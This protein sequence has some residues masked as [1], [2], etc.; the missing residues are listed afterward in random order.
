[1]NPGKYMLEQVIWAIAHRNVAQDD[2]S[3][4]GL[5]G[6]QAARPVNHGGQRLYRCVKV[7]VFPTG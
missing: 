4:I 1:L 3:V 2:L 7:V 6:R 5:D